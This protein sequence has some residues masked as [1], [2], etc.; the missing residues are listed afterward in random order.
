MNPLRYFIEVAQ[1]GSIRAAAD[2]CNV[3][4][5]AISRHVQL[6]EHSAGMTLFE[7]H[8]RGMVM[9]EAGERYLR[10]ARA[11]VLEGER[12][13]ADIDDL[14][15]L[16]SGSL[17]IT[18]VDGIVSGPLSDILATFRS[19]FPGVTIYLKSM[20]TENVMKSV[21]D[22]EADVGIAFHSSPLAGVKIAHRV[23]DP[24]TAIVGLD[25]VLKSRKS[26][27][28]EE[29]MSFPL[30]LPET[31][32]GIRKLVD[33]ACHRH[34]IRA[35][36]M[37][38]TNSIEALRGFART[39]AGVTMMPYLSARRELSMGTV[40][41]LSINEPT[42]LS[43]SSDVGVREEREQPIAVLEFL[44]IIRTDFKP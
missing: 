40:K 20:G 37:L 5:S 25:H 35:K 21:R 39:G 24:L 43:S 2:R 10:Y 26:V 22:G 19:R 17:R 16:R 27:D 13:Q 3:A 11:V 8:P 1:T 23:T 14:K 6:F 34:G 30:A 33:A 32:F 36:M 4:A 44:K 18:A 29:I 38:E 42:L 15:G 41:G 28:F 7:R 31:T 12:A 9:T